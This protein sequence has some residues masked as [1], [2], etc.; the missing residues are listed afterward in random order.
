MKLA[1]E[2]IQKVLK[3]ADFMQVKLHSATKHGEAKSLATELTIALRKVQELN[4]AQQQAQFDYECL[5]NKLKYIKQVETLG[6][7]SQVFYLTDETI[8]KLK[9]IIM[10]YLS[11]EINLDDEFDYLGETYFNPLK[12]SVYNTWW[13]NT[14]GE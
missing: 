7:V 2:K 10:K 11:D 12:E 8:R 3:E 5:E 14:Q 1:S 6:R 9:E 13:D 4:E